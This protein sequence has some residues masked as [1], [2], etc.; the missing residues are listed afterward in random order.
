MEPTEH[1]L[2]ALLLWIGTGLFSLAMV[3]TVCYFF[4][5][6]LKRRH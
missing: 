1:T 4:Y 5:F 3:F 2:D 6:M